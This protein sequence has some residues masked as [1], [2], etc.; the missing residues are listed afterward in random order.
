MV[1]GYEVNG[2]ENIPVDGPALIY[3]Y[4]GALPIDYYFLVAKIVLLKQ[5]S[6]NSVVD[7][8]LFKIPG[9][10]TFLRVF[11]CTP[12]TVETCTEELHQGHLLGM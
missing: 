11:N 9:L 1:F 5:R 7:R 8:F 2:L 6:I 3:Y 4:H 12:G 10:G